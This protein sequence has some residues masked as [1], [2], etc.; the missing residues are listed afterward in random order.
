MAACEDCGAE[1]VWTQLSSARYSAPRKRCPSCRRLL[2]GACLDRHRPSSVP[3]LSAPQVA[4][5][6]AL[7]ATY[8]AEGRCCRG[9]KLRVAMSLRRLGLA[10]QIGA[11]RYVRTERGD[12]IVHAVDVEPATFCAKP[13]GEDG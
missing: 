5:L 11:R 2:C 6:R 4:L 1:P 8:E 9:A 7:D 10:R 12:E 3:A 13:A